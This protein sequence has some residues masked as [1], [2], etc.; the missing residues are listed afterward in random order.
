MMMGVT[1]CLWGIEAIMPYGIAKLLVRDVVA[2]LF[3]LDLMLVIL[4]QR[5]NIFKK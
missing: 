3:I 5:P 1:F 4:E 2:L